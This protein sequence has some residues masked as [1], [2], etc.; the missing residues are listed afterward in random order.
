MSTSSHHHNLK[1]LLNAGPLKPPLTGIGYY[2]HSL[3]IALQARLATEQL[4][5]FSKYHVHS[6]QQYYA[7]E[8][9]RQLAEATGNHH[10]SI[11]E[12]V[13]KLAK[14]I[15]KSVPF[16]Y[17]ARLW[18]INQMIQ[19]CLQEQADQGRIYHETNYIPLPYKGKTVI[20][21]HDMAHVHNPSWHPKE[22]VAYLNKRLPEAITRADAIITDSEFSRTAILEC[23][24][25]AED[26]IFVTLLGKDLE[27]IPY[28]ASDTA[29]TLAALKLRHHGYVFSA[30]TL[31]P[32]KNLIRLVKAHQQLP[33][34]LR[35][36]YPLVLSGAQGWRLPEW[37]ALVT[38]LVESGE[39]ILL[40]YL[41]RQQLLHVYASAVVFAYPSLYEG[42][43]LPIIEAMACGTPVLTSNLG[44]M[45]E[46]AGDAAVTVDPMS[47]DDISQGLLTLLEDQERREMHIRQGL[48]RGQIFTWDHCAT[49]TLDVYQ[50]V[51]Q[52]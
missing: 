4:S 16:A 51:S 6:W 49:Q 37:N 2:S 22:R 11:K 48:V 29:A 32:R 40:G 44:A 1:L 28:S 3:L 42:F 45:Q 50:H 10:P 19:K 34:N 27:C 52:G 41:P 15:V 13:L 24:P 46:V 23:F 26:K 14:P 36:E 39:V 5:V 17:S 25:H 21:V 38:P 35:L 8:Q 43:G 7:E 9:A 31:E 30:C 18:L 20:T 33:K 47:I 12:K